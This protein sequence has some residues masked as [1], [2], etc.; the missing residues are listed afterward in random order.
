[1]AKSKKKS[2]VPAWVYALCL[3]GVAAAAAAV[4]YFTK[5]RRALVFLVSSLTGIPVSVTA[6]PVLARIGADIYALAL[7]AGAGRVLPGWHGSVL[8]AL[9]PSGSSAGGIA[10]LLALLC[11]ASL[12]ADARNWRPDWKVLLLLAGGGALGMYFAD[13]ALHGGEL[14]RNIFGGFLNNPL[15]LKIIFGI[16]ALLTLAHY[17]ANRGGGERHWLLAAPIGPIIGFWSFYVTHA[18]AA[19]MFFLTVFTL[20]VV[21]N[22]GAA[23]TLT[24]LPPALLVLWCARQWFVHGSSALDLLR[25]SGGAPHAW[26]MAAAA[27]GVGIAAFLCLRFVQRLDSKFLEVIF[28]AGLALF[29]L[30]FFAL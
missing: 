7:H 11:A 29:L 19:E 9:A 12:A 30:L 3:F 10:V 26:D 24:L 1:M 13:T 27:G 18:P 5:D 15:Y 17:V 23:R 28:A 22:Y 6:N 25:V 14:A 4:L 8:G 21:M 2:G 20:I 16:L